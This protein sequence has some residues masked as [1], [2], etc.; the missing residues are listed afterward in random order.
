M[1]VDLS[2]HYEIHVL[3]GS[4][5]RDTSINK[6]NHHKNRF[7]DQLLQN[8]MELVNY[9]SL[10]QNK[11]QSCSQIIDKSKIYPNSQA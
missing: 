10:P 8:K 9:M 3:H 1:L 6:D 7:P 5:V 4:A 11:S 2:C